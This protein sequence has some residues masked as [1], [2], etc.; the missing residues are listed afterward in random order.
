MSSDRQDLAEELAAIRQQLSSLSQ[1][2]MALAR[3]HEELAAVVQQ[4]LPRHHEAKAADHPAGSPAQEVLARCGQD[5][6]RVL[7]EVGR[8]LTTL[9]ILDELVHRHLNWRESTVSHTLAELMDQGLVRETK[10]DGPHRY[11]LLTPQC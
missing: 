11:A 8:P 6:V 4:T 3:R 9:E 2:L 10:G 5:I 1:Q 7:R